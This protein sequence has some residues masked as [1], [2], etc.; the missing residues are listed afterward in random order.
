MVSASRSP[1]SIVLALL[2]AFIVVCA[3]S[4]KTQPRA[5]EPP[6][7]PDATVGPGEPEIAP[8]PLTPEEARLLALEDAAR[9][10]AAIAPS[11][12]TAE[13]PSPE[14][15]I[16]EQ[17]LEE[18]L[19]AQLEAERAARLESVQQR[20]LYPEELFGGPMIRTEGLGAGVVV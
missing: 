19:K 11:V 10:E 3:A 18:H 8:E 17:L 5:E 15:G 16:D 13:A 7:A 1:I 4:C 20:I 2:I 6:A 9:S 14:G 12:P